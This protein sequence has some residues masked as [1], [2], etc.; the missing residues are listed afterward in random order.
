ML[1]LYEVLK[2]KNECDGYNTLCPTDKDYLN[3]LGSS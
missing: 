2:I 3:S 1:N